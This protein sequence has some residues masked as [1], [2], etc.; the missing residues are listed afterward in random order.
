[1]CVVAETMY[2][3]CRLFMLLFVC[4]ACLYMFPNAFVV[5]VRFGGFVFPVFVLFALCVLLVGLC[6]F[7][8]CVFVSLCWGICFLMCVC[9]AAV[10][11]CV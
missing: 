9:S 5:C 8:W 7:C 11:F 2:C 6:C 1:M 4:F 10:F 3:V